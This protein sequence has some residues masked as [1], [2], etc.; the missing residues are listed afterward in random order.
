MGRDIKNI[1]A[2]IKRFRREIKNMAK[3]FNGRIVY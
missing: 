1:E 3:K 2:K